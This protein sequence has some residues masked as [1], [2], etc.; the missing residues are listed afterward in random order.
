MRAATGV[1]SRICCHFRRR[2]RAAD[3]RQHLVERYAT[4]A[5]DF[6]VEKLRLVIMDCRCR[7]R[8]VVGA[9]RKLRDFRQVAYDSLTVP[10]MVRNGTVRCRGVSLATKIMLEMDCGS[11][12]ISASIVFNRDNLFA[13]E[14]LVASKLRKP[15]QFGHDGRKL[16]HSA[17]ERACA[18]FRF[19]RRHHQRAY[20]AAPGKTN[21][22]WSNPRINHF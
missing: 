10:R 15:A 18:R 5:V 8:N 1:E 13:V 11:G 7:K 12:S 2:A 22:D 3:D 6:H 4:A 19:I 9:V 17:T 21:C 14:A 16:H 20:R